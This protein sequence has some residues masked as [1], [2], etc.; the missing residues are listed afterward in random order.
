[1]RKL[2]AALAVSSLAI[3][4]EQS[5][6][7]EELDATY[8]ITSENMTDLPPDDRPDRVLVWVTGKGAKDIFDAMPGIAVLVDCEGSATPAAVRKTAGG[9]ECTVIRGTEY[10]CTVAIMLGSGN[11]DQGYI[12]G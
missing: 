5:G 1:M 11:T 6:D 7:F 4:I 3:G 2:I 10:L 12:C 8:A 9:L